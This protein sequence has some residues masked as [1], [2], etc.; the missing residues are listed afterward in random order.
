[1]TYAAL[2]KK[3]LEM[4]AKIKSL[5]PAYKQPGDGSNGVCDC[6]GLIIGA[7]RR[8]SLKWKGIHGSNYGA[9]YETNNL[10]YK[11]FGMFFLS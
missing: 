3:F 9:R 4:V 8:M 7:I 6:I 1:M 11:I 5:N 10:S 2:V